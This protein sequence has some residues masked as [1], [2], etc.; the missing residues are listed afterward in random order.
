M[1]NPEH[2]NILATVQATVKEHGVKALADRLN[3][4]PQT[5][6]A[7]VDP[8]SIGR[9]T[10]KLGLLDWLIL[11]AESGDLSSLDIANR[12]F[13]RISLPMPE[14]AETLNNMSWIEHCALIAKES[15]EAIAE[16]A[17]SILDGRM[18]SAEM[19]RCE[20]ETWDALKAFAGLYIVIKNRRTK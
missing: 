15:G 8:N 6:Y 4:R 1:Y 14:P 19:E 5:L 9:R 16:L 13:G 17:N 7:D 11:L 10:N 12:L 2:I 3:V 20:K 18:E